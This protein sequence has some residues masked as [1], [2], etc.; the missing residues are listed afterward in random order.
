MK[1]LVSES[2]FDFRGG[3]VTSI[4]PDLLNSNELVDATN[5]RIDSKYGAVT[6]RTGCQRLHLTALGSPSAIRGLVQ[7][8]GPSGK[9]LVAIANGHLY[10]R[11]GFNLATAFTDEGTA[12]FS[13]TVPAFFMPFRDATSGALLVLFIAS[14]GKLFKWTGT[15]LTDITAATT[16]ADRIIA[17][18]TRAFAR[19]TNYKKTIFWGKVGDA[20][21][22]ATG[23]KTD[24]GSS[25]VDVLNG[26]EII[27]LEVIG[28]SLL[29]ATEDCVMRF[30]G[31]D[32]TDI[33]ISQGTEGISSEVGVVGPQA[34]KRFENVAGMLNERGPYAVTETAVAPIGEQ[35]LPDFDA[36]D[37]TVLSASVVAWN[38]GRKEL[39]FCV[40][41]SGDSSLN[42]TI[43]AQAV[44]L[45][46]WQ[47]PWTYSFGI[48]CAARY[49]DGNGDEFWIS[50]ATD[51]FIRHMDIGTKDDV[52]YD[53]TGGS[54]ITMLV[55]LPPFHFGRPGSQ[56]A[57]S[58][59]KLQATIPVGHNL[60]MQTA[61]DNEAFDTGYFV[62]GTFDGVLRD[63]RVD[64]D[65]Y[66]YRLR[67]KF[68]DSSAVAPAI[69]GFRINAYDMSRP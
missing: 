44:R 56:K 22:F 33:V 59:S 43:Y 11:N 64:H 48:S 66:G 25:L 20:T 4:S 58:H 68:T 1:E 10:Y 3:R 27:A 30:T 63:Y 54:N 38:R 42:K 62:G 52:L 14:G 17:Y 8:D 28:S 55:E 32:S 9:Q 26:E 65:G 2:R 7:W 50:G 5:C 15:V 34:L 40:P 46:A 69:Y 24:G 36:L 6:K 12:P 61:F 60:T 19:N 13:T 51:G 49:E 53:S 29:M 16:A 18:H 21:S 31:Q 45:Q 35:V 67:T 39:L 57:L 23:T 47:G 37:T 41:G